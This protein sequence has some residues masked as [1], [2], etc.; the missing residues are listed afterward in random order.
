M[1]YDKIA[2]VLYLVTLFLIVVALSQW[3]VSIVIL[4]VLIIVLFQKIST[5]EKIEKVDKKRG[6]I[7]NLVTERLD[8]FSNKTEAMKQNLNKNMFVIENRI[9]EIREKMVYPKTV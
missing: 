2:L 4:L 7:I 5:E 3:E 1:M 9:L 6:E 8:A